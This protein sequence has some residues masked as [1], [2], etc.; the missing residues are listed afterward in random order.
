M[1]SLNETT[2]FDLVDLNNIALIYHKKPIGASKNHIAERLFDHNKTAIHFL[3]KNIY[4]AM[5]YE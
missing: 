2:L 1:A 5:E 3:A 4:L